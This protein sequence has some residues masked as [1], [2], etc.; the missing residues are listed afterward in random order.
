MKRSVIAIFAT[1]ALILGN[2]PAFGGETINGPIH[3]CRKPMLAGNA[4]FAAGLNP[5]PDAWKQLAARQAEE[6]KFC[7]MTGS[8]EL[9]E[10]GADVDVGL[11]T[12]CSEWM[13]TA[14]GETVFVVIGPRRTWGTCP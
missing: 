4:A 1:T 9:L 8:V 5:G 6:A 13:A 11:N 12:V 7:Y 14:S 2:M 10:K 3:V